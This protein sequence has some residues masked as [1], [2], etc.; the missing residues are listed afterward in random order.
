MIAS[1]AMA[2]SLLFSGCGGGKSYAPP[3]PASD[4]LRVIGVAYAKATASLGRPPANKEDLLPFLPKQQDPDIGEPEDYFRSKVDG[5][6][7]VIHWGVDVRA[8]N[9]SGRP[10]DLPVLAYEK[11]GEDGKRLVL[12]GRYVN[13]VTDEELAKLPFP[14]GY[15]APK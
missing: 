12:Q 8:L 7:F 5:E 11:K 3:A 9:M 1:A 10:A 15:H 4:Q 6:E 13:Q 14:A 2:L